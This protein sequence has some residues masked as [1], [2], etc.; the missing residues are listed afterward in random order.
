MH[1]G[2]PQIPMSSPSP[3][4]TTAAT[5]TAATGTA[6]VCFGAVSFSLVPSESVQPS[7][8][9]QI[10]PATPWQPNST[11]PFVL[12]GRRSFQCA[13]ALSAQDAHQS[14]SKIKRAVAI[15]NLDKLRADERKTPPMCGRSK[16]THLLRAIKAFVSV[17]SA[18]HRSRAR[19]AVR[20][21]LLP[22]L[23][24]ATGL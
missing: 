23:S 5:T 21:P 1:H 3:E 10:A 11:S 20:V 8:N 4:A 7:R 15:T 16:A 12:Q 6:A 17:P 24:R 19:D 2:S 14:W 13:A 22:F 9:N 18:T